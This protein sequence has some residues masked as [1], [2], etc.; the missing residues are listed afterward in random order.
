MTKTQNNFTSKSQ[1]IFNSK[2]KTLSILIAGTHLFI[3]SPTTAHADEKSVELP[4][5]TISTERMGLSKEYAGGQVA[6]GAKLGVLG[7]QDI[8]DTPFSVTS[9]TSELIETQQARSV[10]DILVN[11]DASVRQ[12]G[13]SGDL[14][15]DFTIRGFPVSAQDVAV[16]GMYGLLPYWRVPVEFAERVELFKGPTAMLSGLSPSG[17]IGGA[18]N[19]VPKRA[20]IDPLT[21]LSMQF[22]PDG[23]TG[24]HVD[25][26]R[27]F[28]DNNE[29]G[30]RFNGVYRN[31]DTAVEDTSREFSLFS[32]G[33]D[34]QGEKLSLETDILYQKARLDGIQRP[35]ILN[36]GIQTLPSAPDAEKLF[37]M[38]DSYSDSRTL[39]VITRANYS[40]NSNVDLFAAVGH[41]KND[42]DTQAANTFIT[43]SS[44]GAAS[45]GSARQRSDRDTLSAEAGMRF[46]FNTTF[47]DHELT[48][49][50]NRIDSTEG[51][52]YSFFSPKLGN[53][54]QTPTDFNVDGSALDGNVPT[55][56]KYAFQGLSLTDQ[57]SMLDDKLKFTV[58]ARRQWIESK[59]YDRNSGL[60]TQRYNEQLW[61]PLFALSYALTDQTM[62]YANM[63]EGL[64][65]GD[66]APV[67][68]NNP[69]ETLA[70]YET[71]QYEM[72]VK[73]DT[74]NFGASLAAFQIEKPNAF[75]D[76][77]NTFRADGEQ[78]NRGIEINMFGEPIDGL[79]VLAGVSYLVPELLK[80]ENGTNDGNDAIGVPREQANLGVYWD[81]PSL[82]G[83]SLNARWIYTG[84]AN[85]DPANDIKVPSWRRYDVG[86]SYR[87]THSGTPVLISLNVQNLLNDDYWQSSSSYGGVSIN[88]PR[89]V[90][91][92]TT[93]DF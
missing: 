32:L 41:R 81:V 79:R 39:T 20:D 83:A 68:A 85:Y 61:T 11:N 50:T 74:G 19:I 62:I 18:I 65:Q 69:G 80:T 29:F 49:A 38:K 51:L 87:F 75:V 66:S 52:A 9:Y 7:E 22:T 89:T 25:I 5:L 64:S 10:A 12:I 59:N 55:T 24:T 15:N 37:G 73:Y 8:M 28:G 72:G 33:V 58:G 44:S 36:P 26:G 93:I 23:E 34:Y 78:R 70:P 60:R 21:R 91:L 77:S 14:N 76:A 67:S 63:I 1:F 84:E 86:A 56:L 82:E 40:L 90:T 57:M 88:S 92:S 35:V 16:N 3:A 47:I 30:V 17:S 4:S 53:L 2:Y 27:R 45:F 46:R 71:R 42:W 48:V 43:D 13:S 6:S 31:G 54:Y